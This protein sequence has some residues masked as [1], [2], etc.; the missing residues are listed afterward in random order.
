MELNEM[1]DYE[2]KA[3]ELLLKRF[4]GIL[5]KHN[6]PNNI[7]KSVNEPGM[8]DGL[9]SQYWGVMTIVLN[10]AN[11]ED[12]AKK[13]LEKL[14]ERVEATRPKPE[15]VKKYEVEKT[16][17]KKGEK[18]T[19]EDLAYHRLLELKNPY[20]ETEIIGFK[21][22]FSRLCTMFCMPKN[23]AFIVLHQLQDKGLIEIVPH[24]GIMI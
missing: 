18:I 1:Q 6:M 4:N 16:N 17:I 12:P 22:V 13:N 20:K 23:D 3:R 19:I 24:K 15:R 11:K 5:E 9:Y 8:F 10:S 2:Q 21:D 7:M 14:K